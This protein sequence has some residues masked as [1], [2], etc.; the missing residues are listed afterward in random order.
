MLNYFENAKVLVRFAMI[1][2]IAK[3]DMPF[4]EPHIATQGGVLIS[5]EN[6]TQEEW[7]ECIKQ[8]RQWL[9]AQNKKEWECTQ[10]KLR[11]ENEIVL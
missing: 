4:N 10:A 11:D 1:C 8:Y 5:K 9:Y 6:F 3:E 2:Y 7:D